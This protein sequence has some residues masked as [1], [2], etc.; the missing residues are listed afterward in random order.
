MYLYVFYHF[1]IYTFFVICHFDNKMKIS[2][3]IYLL[4]IQ[5]IVDPKKID[6]MQISRAQVKKNMAKFNKAGENVRHTFFVI[7]HFDNKM[8]ISTCIYLLD[9][10]GIVDPKKIN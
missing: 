9:I 10:Q 1:R 2:T 4:D 3:C 8:K 7:C 6:G 5:G